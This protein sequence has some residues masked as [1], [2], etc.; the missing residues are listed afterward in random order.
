MSETVIV[1]VEDARWNSVD[2]SHLAERGFGAVL[3]VLGLG[4]DGYE[5]TVLGCNDAK[6]SQLNSDFRQKPQPTNVLSWPS[7][8]LVRPHPD[9]PPCLPPTGTL[10]QPY[11][12]GDIAI[13]YE[14]CAKESG[15]FGKEMSAHV[16]HLLVH[17]TLHLFGYDHVVT[18]D[19]EE[20]ENLERQAL[21]ILGQPDPYM[22][23]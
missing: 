11:E 8:D 9:G 5:A 19:A 21:A 10:E 15:E 12:L 7:A 22:D 20:M 13:S 18:K 14:T 16:L 4:P 23:E 6:I 17:G 1:L 2:L 3:S